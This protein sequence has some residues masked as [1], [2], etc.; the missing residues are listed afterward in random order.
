MAWMDCNGERECGGSDC[1]R[2]KEERKAKYNR[3][4]CVFRRETRHTKLNI[5]S[6]DARK[7]KESKSSVSRGCQI[8]I[9]KRQQLSWIKARQDKVEIYRLKESRK[10]RRLRGEI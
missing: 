9:G 1:M 3:F 5:T 7:E 6:W 4:F 10:E 8:I 2:G